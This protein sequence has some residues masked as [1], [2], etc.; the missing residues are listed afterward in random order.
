MDRIIEYD[1]KESDSNIKIYTFLKYRNGYSTHLIRMLKFRDNGILLNGAPAK[2]IDLVNTGDKLVVSIPGEESDI[3]PVDI[4]LDIVYE[5]DDILIINKPPTLA[6]HPTHNHQGDTLANGVVFHLLKE[7]KSTSYKAVG[8]LDK[9]TSGLVV[10]AL[11]LLAACK[12]SGKTEKEYEAVVKGQPAQQGTVSTP[13]Y[14]PNPMKTLRACSDE[15]GVEKAVTHW[16]VV[17]RYDNSAKIALKLETG[18]THQIR[19]HMASIG[20]PLAGDSFYGDF[21]P[22]IG[23]QM[24]TC[25]KCSFIHPV[26]GEKMHFEI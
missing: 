2:T 19:V 5:D 25:K 18:R 17:E 23:H 10:L 11:N 13:I 14:R 26:T 7:G 3:E 4:P 21:K 8:R 1:I 9:G 24:L 20:H 6:M 16:K 22:E 12:L 15:L